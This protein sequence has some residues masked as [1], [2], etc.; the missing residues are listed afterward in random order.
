MGVMSPIFW[1]LEMIFFGHNPHSTMGVMAEKRTAIIP[2]IV[3]PHI[4]KESR[5][6]QRRTHQV[7][8]SQSQPYF[9]QER[10]YLMEN[11]IFLLVGGRSAVPFTT[12]VH[13]VLICLFVRN[14]PKN[15]RN[16]FFKSYLFYPRVTSIQNFKVETIALKN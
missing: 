6:V 11:F 15:D 8:I 10:G 16:K 14:I 12:N 1:G 7:Q 9:I 13:K 3:V 4:V 5:T 2:I